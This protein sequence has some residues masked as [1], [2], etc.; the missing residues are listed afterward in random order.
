MS[1]T[2]P[3][4]KW[5]G[6]KYRLLDRILQALPAGKRLVEPFGGSGA[7]FIN[8][9]FSEFVISEANLDLVQLYRQLQSEG[10]GFIHYCAQYF[11]PKTNQATV[12]YHHR[13]L[14]NECTD[15]RERSA[16]FLYLNRHGYNG[17][18]R[19][20]LS[21]KFNVPFGAYV[22]PYFPLREMQ[23]FYK[24]SQSATFLHQ[25]FRKTFSELAQGDVVYCDPPYVKLSKTAS[26]THYT[27][28]HFTESDQLMLAKLAETASQNGNDVVI[29]NHDTQFTRQH[30]KKSKMIS[31]PVQRFISC[32]SASRAEPVQELV[33][34][35]KKHPIK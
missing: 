14:F 4:L 30:Y 7:V 2:K 16:L 31:F 11:T 17:L 35:F 12:Y 22:R 26:F 29:S 34:I 21:G 28:Q 8:A 13:A 24:K 23:H 27:G 6:G 5:A 32:A 25:D 18:C 20:N 19:Y 1:Y 3:F 10:D 9:P 15:I 33:A